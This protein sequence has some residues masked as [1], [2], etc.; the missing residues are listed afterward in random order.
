MYYFSPQS[1]LKLKK[2]TSFEGEG[3]SEFCWGRGNHE[4]LF[5]WGTSIYIIDTKVKRFREI[6]K[7]KKR[8]RSMSLSPDQ[9]YLSF[10]QDQNLWIFNFKS[11]FVD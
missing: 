2:I 11:I 7:S 10:I 8:K 9:K 5:I 3:I 6:I 1:D 4:I